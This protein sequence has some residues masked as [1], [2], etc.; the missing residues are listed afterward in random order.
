MRPPTITTSTT[1][2]RRT[3]ATKAGPATME[4]IDRQV[5]YNWLAEADYEG[6][7]G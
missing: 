6:A 1:F 5:F 7:V 3:L 2:S 4:N